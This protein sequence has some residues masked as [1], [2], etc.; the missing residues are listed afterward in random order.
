[1]TLICVHEMY[2]GEV[3]E[4]VSINGDIPEIK[5]L[6]NMGIREGK[7][8][9]LLHHDPLATKKVVIGVDSTR[10]A[11]DVELAYNIKVRPLKS[12]F[13][14]VKTQAQYDNLTGCFNRHEANRI[15]KS[16]YEKF[17]TKGSPLSLLIADIDFFKKINDVHGHNAGDE[18]LRTFA[19]LLRQNMKRSDILCRWGGEEFLILLRG[20]PVNN[21]VQVAERLRQSIEAY[22]FP[23]FKNSGSVTASIGGCGLPPDRPIQLLIETAD[24]ALYMAKD[25][26]RNQVRICDD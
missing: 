19:G 4:I 6:R 13:E 2:I 16:E 26:G 21:T 23:P 3:A 18:V 17:I 7:I 8:I 24:K 9:D 15:L 5:R 22:V 11:F 25:N 1:M 10:V 12:Y 20:T 14:T